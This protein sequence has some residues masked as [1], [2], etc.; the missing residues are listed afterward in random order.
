MEDADLDPG[1]KKRS[2]IVQVP[3][4]FFSTVQVLVLVLFKEVKELGSVLIFFA[5]FN[6][7]TLNL[8]NF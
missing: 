8:N 3:E 5:L 6:L 4:D 2:L 1:G 7:M